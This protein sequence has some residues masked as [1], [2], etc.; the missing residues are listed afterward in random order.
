M[1]IN[2]K[3]SGIVVLI[4]LSSILVQGQCKDLQKGGDH[5]VPLMGNLY[6]DFIAQRIQSDERLS[7]DSIDDAFQQSR[8][9]PVRA[10]L[11]SAIVPGAGQFYTRSYWQSAAF[12]GAEVLMWI[13][14]AAN[15]SKGNRQTNDFQ[16]YSDAN[17][18]VV[19]YA[20]WIRDNYSGNYRSDIFNGT[21]PSPDISKPWLYINWDVLNQVE[22][23][24]GQ[25]ATQNIRTG[26]SHDLPPR[27]DQQ[28]YEEIGKYPQYGGGWNDAASFKAGGLTTTDV[29]DGNVSP[30]FLSYSRMRGDA[31]HSYDIATSVSYLIVANH[32]F[33]AVEAAWNASRI[34]NR[35]HL[36]GHIRSRVIGEGLVEFVPTIDLE[37]GL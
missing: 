18:S 24:I 25:L 13:V 34:N 15:E 35:I 32:I 4:L 17:W 29:L 14:Y 19:R 3:I 27:P 31:N 21:P 28:Y 10:G 2:M 37:I 23:Q 7:A 11:F 1:S 12:L 6:C 5:R 9:S 16:N 36:Q 20:Y 30:N 22:D 26:F 8:Y 33:S